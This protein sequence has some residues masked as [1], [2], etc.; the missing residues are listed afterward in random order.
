MN[1]KMALSTITLNE[2]RL[3]YPIKRYAMAEWIT[4][5]PLHKL[6]IRN[7]FQ[8]ER[9]TQTKSEKG[10]TSYFMKMKIGK[11]NLG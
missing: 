8:I 1:K 4:M 3:N 6:S 10:R 7:S 5:R 9:H 11:K 2:N